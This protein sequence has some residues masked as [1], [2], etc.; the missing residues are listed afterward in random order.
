[1]IKNK[2]SF[3]IIILLHLQFW[4][5]SYFQTATYPNPIL[6]ADNEQ[7][8]VRYQFGE[9]RII[10]SVEPGEYQP[11]AYIFAV[12]HRGAIDAPI[13]Q[14]MFF[15]GDMLEL[16][17]TEN[18][19]N[20]APYGNV[21]V[22]KAIGDDLQQEE[23]SFSFTDEE[24][25]ILPP[26]QLHKVPYLYEKQYIK[27]SEEFTDSVR[28]DN[29]GKGV[30]GLVEGLQIAKYPKRGSERN[31]SSE[32]DSISINAIPDVDQIKV[33]IFSSPD[34]AELY[35]D[36]QLRG[37]TPLGILDLSIGEHEFRLVKDNFAPL[38]K[39]LDIQPSK[40]AKIEFRMNRLNTLHFITQE[41]GLKYVFDDDHEWWDKNIKLLVENGKHT[42][43]VYKSGELVDELIL[44]SDWS[45]RMEYSLPDTIAAV[46]DST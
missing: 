3:N 46:Q 33:F 42:F 4:G 34:E 9:I 19:L 36:G 26:F 29:G 11:E 27:L 1:L 23:M 45:T 25:I 16:M 6:I 2:T 20:A 39:T 41:E 14:K 24:E 8:Y 17:I 37:K 7:V 28:L 22:L 38:V 5:C 18:H 35:I 15:P 10:G 40:R 32:F 12:F 44:D 43:K 30:A 31:I 13:I 21:A